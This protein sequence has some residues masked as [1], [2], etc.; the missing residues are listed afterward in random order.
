MMLR[1][2]LEQFKLKSLISWKNIFSH[3]RYS[4]LFNLFRDALNRCDIL[5]LG[6]PSFLVLATDDQLYFINTLGV[7][8]Q[9]YNILG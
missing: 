7:F 8:A 3:P 4:L 9:G 2:S 5:P 1:H 6:L